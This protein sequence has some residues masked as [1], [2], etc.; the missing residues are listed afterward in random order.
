MTD[1]DFDTDRERVEQQEQD[2]QPD[3]RDL[4]EELRDL[5]EM[6]QEKFDDS[7]QQG[8]DETLDS[9]E[10]V[11]PDGIQ[12]TGRENDS[13]E[14]TVE[15]ADLVAETLAKELQISRRTDYRS[16]LTTGSRV[17]QT[18]AHRLGQNDTRIY[19][20]NDPGDEK[21]YFIALVLDRSN[22]MGRRSNKIDVA[23]E[24]AA[25][26]TLAC[27]DLG[28][29]VAV[30]DFIGGEARLAKPACIEANEAREILT[31]TSHGG[32]TPLSDALEI[33][34]GLSERKRRESIIITMTDGLPVSNEDTKAVI[35]ST[36]TP[37]CSLTIATDCE[38]GNPPAQAEE[39]EGAYERSETVFKPDNLTDELD[40]LAAELGIF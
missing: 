6:L 24:A 16:G 2:L 25:Q 23:T 19:R 20:R 9:L 35:D 13:W 26:F 29:N 1:D 15:D 40:R 17:D 14:E 31:D 5:E 18:K 8:G 27:E 39:L 7:H 36:Y 21:E 10:I 38:P 30:I 33:A 32:G 4:E 22:S 3:K 34:V 12:Q 37:V 11:S 28:I